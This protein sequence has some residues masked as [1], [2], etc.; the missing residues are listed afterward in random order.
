MNSNPTSVP[1]S[2][3]PTA[4]ANPSQPSSNEQT[5]NNTSNPASAAGEPTAS[6]NS[7]Q[8][9]QKEQLLEPLVADGGGGD[10]DEPARDEVDGDALS[11]RMS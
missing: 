7:S 3:E 2:G 8:P 4:S 9:N 5:M 1:V 10:G 11:L 6:A